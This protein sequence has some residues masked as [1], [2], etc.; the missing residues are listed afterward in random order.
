MLEACGAL[1]SRA[2]APPHFGFTQAWGPLDVLMPLLFVG[3][4]YAFCDLVMPDAPKDG[5]VL[6]LREYHARQGHRYK[7]LQLLFA[8]LALV[9]IALRSRDVGDW[10]A[11]SHF[12]A[13]AVVCSLVALRTRRVWLDTVATLVLLGMAP[14]SLWMHLQ[15]LAG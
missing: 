12:A 15:G 10:L 5:R 4:L 11:G 1:R 13:V 14:I 3:V 6:D 7:T 8:V 2:S 9:V